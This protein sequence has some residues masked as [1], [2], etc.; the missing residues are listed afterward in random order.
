MSTKPFE[1]G[2][3]ARTTVEN[4]ED[5][6]NYGKGVEFEVE[7]YVTAEEAESDDWYGYYNGSNNG[8]FNNVEVR[9]DHV[10]LVRSRE[11]MRARTLP[12]VSDIAEH[13]GSE[14][15]G[16]DFDIHETDWG[17]GDGIIYLYGKTPEGLNFAATVKVLDVER[18]DF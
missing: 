14:A 2:S 10:E 16:G 15:M 4:R 13:I 1:P 3:M 9:E 5:G 11:D 8:G 6:Y 17:G 18:T 12:T 7:D